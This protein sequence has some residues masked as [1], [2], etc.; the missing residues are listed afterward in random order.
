VALRTRALAPAASDLTTPGLFIR[1]LRAGVRGTLRAGRSL[2][3]D[4]APDAL[5]RLECDR[6]RLAIGIA[7]GD[8]IPVDTDDFIWAASIPV[9]LTDL[10]GRF[11]HSSW[12]ALSTLRPHHVR[13]YTVIRAPT[14][15]EKAQGFRSG[16]GVGGPGS[17]GFWCR[18]GWMWG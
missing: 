1:W 11:H 15:I 2:Q 8:V 17:S 6:L 7:N 9:A 13:E 5:S 10:E 12:V 14:P 4:V 18:I 3:L 16:S